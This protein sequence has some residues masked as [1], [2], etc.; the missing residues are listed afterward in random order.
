MTKHQ[1]NGQPINKF[2]ADLHRSLTTGVGA[3]DDV[4][5]DDVP[6]DDVPDSY[7][8]IVHADGSRQWSLKA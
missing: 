6:G 2:A 1:K 7:V 4:P 8:E 5:G 3:G